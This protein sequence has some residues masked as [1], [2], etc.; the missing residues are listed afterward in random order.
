LIV[1]SLGISSEQRAMIAS[2]GGAARL[3]RHANLQ[4]QV[5]AR[6]ELLLA[7]A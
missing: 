4:N 5:D 6:R 3:F 1:V 7:A 2:V